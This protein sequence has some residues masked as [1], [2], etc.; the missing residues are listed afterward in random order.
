MV[1]TLGA[2]ESGA[3]EN[4]ARS[5]HAIDDLIVWLY[6]DTRSTAHILE[7]TINIE[8]PTHYPNFEGFRNDYRADIPVLTLQL[9][10]GG[11]DDD[12]FENFKSILRLLGDQDVCYINPTETLSEIVR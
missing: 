3:E 1:V 12:R 6:G 2:L 10:P 8:Q 7:R 11:W 4:G 9:H 5:I